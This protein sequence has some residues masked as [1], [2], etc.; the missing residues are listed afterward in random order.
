[1][2]IHERLWG[3]ITEAVKFVAPTALS[4]Q[5]GITG[6]TLSTSSALQTAVKDT[7][8][9]IVASLKPVNDFLN[10]I[11]NPFSTYVG[12]KTSTTQVTT[13]KDTWI[14]WVIIIVVVIIIILVLVYMARK[15]RLLRRMKR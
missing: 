4:L 12:V 10:P 15:L 2:V 13:K 14:T 3:G 6:A 1:M 8:S 9:R 11:L 5:A 7:G